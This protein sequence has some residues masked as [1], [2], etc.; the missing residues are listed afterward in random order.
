MR[1]ARLCECEFSFGPSFVLLMWQIFSRYLPGLCP[2]NSRAFPGTPTAAMA[3]SKEGAAVQEMKRARTQERGKGSD[4][5]DNPSKKTPREAVL[6]PIAS[7]GSNA[8]LSGSTSLHRTMPPS[9]R[10]AAFLVRKLYFGCRPDLSPLIVHWHKIIVS[11]MTLQAAH[12]C[13]SCSSHAW[14]WCRCRHVNQG[15]YRLELRSTN[16]PVRIAWQYYG[17]V[18]EGTLR[19]LLHGTKPNTIYFDV[20]LTPSRPESVR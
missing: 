20:H 1:D 7:R 16:T 9:P 17:L 10:A 2:R 8:V 5:R 12:S 15:H 18:A 19:L 3:D 14:E 4:V 6:S 13:S 11:T